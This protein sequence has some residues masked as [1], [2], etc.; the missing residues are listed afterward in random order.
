M[1]A[2]N[3]RCWSSTGARRCRSPGRWHR[4]NTELW[5][6]EDRIRER[7]AQQRFDAGFIELA[8][9]VY[10]RNDER[11]AIKQRINLALDSAI[12]EEKSYQPYR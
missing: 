4:V 7:E 10:L 6:I 3:W 11:A 9:A 12:I 5:D 1:C 2:G 8:R